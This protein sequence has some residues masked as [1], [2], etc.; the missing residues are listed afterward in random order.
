VVKQ[1]EKF[2]KNA[3][4]IDMICVHPN[5]LY[6]NKSELEFQALFNQFLSQPTIFY[7]YPYRQE[8][9]LSGFYYRGSYFYL[10]QKTNEIR[11][12][13]GRIGEEIL[14]AIK[15]NFSHKKGVAVTDFQVLC[16]IYPF[17][18]YA[19]NQDGSLAKIYEE[20]P[21]LIPF[22]VTSLNSIIQSDY[23][24]LRTKLDLI[25]K[26]YETPI[27]EFPIKS[28]VVILAKKNF[29]MLGKV[30]RHIP[31]TD[32]DYDNLSNKNC[33]EY[34]DSQTNYDLCNEDY[35]VSFKQFYKGLL[36]EVSINESFQI[37]PITD[38][39]F[40]KNL[41]QNNAKESYTKLLDLAKEMKILP[42]TLNIITSNCF[43]VNCNEHEE[44]ARL[45]DLQHW[46]I[47]LNLKGRIK[48]QNM[49]LPGYTRSFYEE[50]FSYEESIFSWEFSE[51]AVKLLQEYKERFPYVFECLDKYQEVYRSS[52]YY[53]SFE[54]FAQIDNLDQKLNEV[55][56]FINNTNLSKVSFASSDSL[57]IPTQTIKSIKESVTKK[58]AE[59]STR[60][61]LFS[62]KLF[63]NPNYAYIENTPWTPMFLT[64]APPHFELGDRV[65]NLSSTDLKYIPFGLK[66]TV[67]AVGDNYVEVVFDSSFFGGSTLNG[68]LEDRSGITVNPLALLNLTR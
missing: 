52:K 23:N 1:G 60:N 55:V 51:E 2:K 11:K 30:E 28:V 47:G 5:N 26:N 29:G 56:S 65:V 21:K 46:N 16:E 54:L 19:R 49:I 31:N 3:K 6:Q 62:T 50:H 20:R 18:R 44:N 25:K 41:L 67:S 63:L 59:L 10:D 39:V 32:K 36:L 14:G 22:E 57:F 9:Y 68:R 33:S 48:N 43:V 61:K 15:H 53:K 27:K 38:H 7:N 4:K 42:S 58:V 17:K 45:S 34:Y 64:D 35:K 8:G 37:S 66:G 13:G 40:A 12:D 24:E